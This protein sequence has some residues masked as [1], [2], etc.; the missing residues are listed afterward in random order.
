M[1]T[2]EKQAQKIAARFIRAM[3]YKREDFKNKIE[4]HLIGAIVHFYKITLAQKHGHKQDIAH[5]NKEINRFLKE[6]MV[7]ELLHSIRGF[8]DR[9]T[10]FNEAVE[11]I[12]NN[13][14]SYKKYAETLIKKNYRLPKLKNKITEQDTEMFWKQVNSVAE[15]ALTAMQK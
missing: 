9:R 15:D 13:D 14:T 5:W 12:K 8:K 2:S 1:K 3:A 4:S 11:E 6:E 7:Y 10:A